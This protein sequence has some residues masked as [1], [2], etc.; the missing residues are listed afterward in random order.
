[1]NFCCNEFKFKLNWYICA[2]AIDAV[3]NFAV[4]ECVT[5]K[6]FHCINVSFVVLK[7]LVLKH[8][9]CNTMEL[10][11][12]CQNVKMMCTGVQ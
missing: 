7:Y 4:I 6:S 10:T 8:F 1:M 11:E 9:N 3:K 5:I 12:K 2:N